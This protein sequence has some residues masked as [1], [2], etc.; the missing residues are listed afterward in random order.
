[1]T[2]AVVQSSDNVVIN[3]VMVNDQSEPPIGCFFVSCDS[4]DCN[5]G[6]IY[7]P[8]TGDFV[9]PNPPPPDVGGVE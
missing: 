9:D 8:A 1:M 6:W 5:I 3:I 4:R 2:A 7:D